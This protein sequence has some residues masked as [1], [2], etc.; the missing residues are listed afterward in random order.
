M[1]TRRMQNVA[2]IVA[3]IV[4]ISAVMFSRYED[5]K[6]KKKKNTF[7]DFI[8]AAE[9]LIQRKYS[10]SSRLCIQVL[11]SRECRVAKEH[12][13]LVYEAANYSGIFQVSILP[14]CS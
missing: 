4:S 3:F 11:P 8:A 6:F 14:F 12:R 10:Q 9:H 1:A 5:G 13:H 7:T 2:R